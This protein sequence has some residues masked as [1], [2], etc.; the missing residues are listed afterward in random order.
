MKKYTFEDL[1]NIMDTLLGENGCPWDRAQTHESISG[2]LI[3]ECYEA[4]D[5]IKS[6]NNEALCEELGDVCLHVVFHGKLAEKDGAFTVDDIIHG[7]SEKMIRRHSHVFGTQ[8]ADNMDES[9]LNWENEKQKEKA[10]TS[11]ADKMH[12]VPKSFPA[13][14][15]AQKV[16]GIASRIAEKKNQTQNDE[17]L[18]HCAEFEKVFSNFLEAVKLKNTADEALIGELLFEISNVSR[19]LKL[20]AEIALTNQI[21]TYINNFE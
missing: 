21:E 6:Q 17:I 2:G 7:I 4:V 20:N 12:K 9:L 18:N 3:E 8:K 10:Y 5:T 14:L 11:D 1:K 19:K 15:R 13:L 16:T